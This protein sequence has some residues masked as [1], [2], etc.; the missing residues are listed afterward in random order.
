MEEKSKEQ[1]F[2]QLDELSNKL[3]LEV[4][5]IRRRRTI[6]RLLMAGIFTCVTIVACAFITTINEKA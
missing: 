4:K 2:A 3:D 5:K 1:L 6:E